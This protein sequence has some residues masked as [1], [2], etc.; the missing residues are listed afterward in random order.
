MYRTQKLFTLAAVALTLAVS[1]QMAIAKGAAKLIVLK[2]KTEVCKKGFERAEV[3]TIKIT[4]AGAVT[5]K[6]K[7]GQPMGPIP[8][9]PATAIGYSALK[10]GD[11]VC[12][13][14]SEE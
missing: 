11:I 6:F 5:V 4:A 8:K 14:G 10:V 1:S 7:V 9:G 2:D 13:P 3:E 12:M